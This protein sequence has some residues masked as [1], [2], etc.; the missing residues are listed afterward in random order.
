[1]AMNEEAENNNKNEGKE[2]KKE[3]DL[4]LQQARWQVINAFTCAQC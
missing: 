4:E 2:K 3:K 1:M